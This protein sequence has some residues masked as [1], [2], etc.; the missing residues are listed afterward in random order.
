M[1]IRV[2]RQDI[3]DGRA[4]AGHTCG[5]PIQLALNRKLTGCEN[6]IVSV[7][8]FSRAKF[9]RIEIILPQSA[10]NFQ[11]ALMKDANAKVKPFAF[12][13]EVILPV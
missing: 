4:H 6:S 13:A 2:T 7:P 9:G 12:D 10:I 3:E 11:L 8:K 5:C 1:K